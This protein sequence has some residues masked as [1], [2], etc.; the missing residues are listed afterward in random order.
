LS[1]MT[2]TLGFYCSDA[3]IVMV[4]DKDRYF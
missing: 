2:P 1:H 3:M 4:N